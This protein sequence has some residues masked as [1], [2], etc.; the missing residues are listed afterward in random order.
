M[1]RIDPSVPTVNAR[2]EATIGRLLIAMTYVAVTLLVLG[3]ALMAAAGISPLAAGP[4]LDLA[5]LA[6]Q[7]AAA[8]PAG[9]LYLG[10][11][12]VIATPITRVIGAALSYGADRQWVMVG[13]SV[14]I[15]GV[16]ALGVAIAFAGTV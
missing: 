14:A 2:A 13:V 15:L 3:V 5:T 8:A 10:I 16:I 7:V 6:S 1:S 4:S 12:V 11:I 9:I